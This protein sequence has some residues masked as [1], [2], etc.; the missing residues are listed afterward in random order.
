MEDKKIGKVLN[1]ITKYG[2][3]VVLVMCVIGVAIA[4]IVLVPQ[5][6]VKKQPQK[7]ESAENNEI[8]ENVDEP[9]VSVIS[10]KDERL[11]LTLDPQTGKPADRIHPALSNKQTMPNFTK[12]PEDSKTN[13]T[14]LLNP[15]VKGEIIWKFAMN[16]LIYSSTLDQWTTHSGVDIACKKGDKIRAVADGIVESVY[17]DDAYGVTV[18][19]KH[20]NGDLSVY[21]NL[22][23]EAV[24]SE[25]TYICANDVIGKCGDSAKFECESEPHIHFEYHVDGKPVNPADYIRFES[26]K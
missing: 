9:I 21:S 16:E 24:I 3:Y 10:G 18:T 23:E 22:S 6:D 12:K 4:A 5:N 20:D 2:T 1:I 11:D 8:A 13:S 25:G 15:P 7:S 19:I 26:E 17:T 14:N